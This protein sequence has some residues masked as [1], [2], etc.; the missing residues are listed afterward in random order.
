MKKNRKGFTLVELVIVIAILG[1]LALYA[2]P[3]YQG[4]VEEARSSQ[5][6]AQVGTVRSALGIYYAK[7]HGVYPA[8][9]CDTS[10]P[11]K[12]DLFAE[13][14]V[15]QVEATNANGSVIR[16]N[17]VVNVTHYPIDASDYT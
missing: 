3:K 14:V 17:A 1:I 5:A 6:Q 16:S 7:N 4:L 9:L 13:G 2:V 12:S 8:T 10:N 15:P 11:P